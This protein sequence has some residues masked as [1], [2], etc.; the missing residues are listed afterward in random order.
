[1]TCSSQIGGPSLAPT[2]LREVR[3]SQSIGGG[4]LRELAPIAVRLAG[5]HHRAQLV[6]RGDER[7][8][9]GGCYGRVDAGHA[10]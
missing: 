2:G 5:A 1:M 7:G 4:G 6:Q 8:A 10:P 9:G 3:P